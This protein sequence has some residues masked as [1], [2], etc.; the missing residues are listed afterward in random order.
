MAVYN[1]EKYLP[2]SIKNILEQTFSDFEL[3][4]VDDNSK[5]RTLEILKNYKKKDERIRVINNYKNLGAFGALNEGLRIANGSYIAIHDHDDISDINRLST[6]LDVFKKNNN[7]GLLGSSYYIIDPSGNILEK[8]DVLCDEDQIRTQIIKSNPFCHGSIMFKREVIE[9]V[10]FYRSKFKYSGDF[11]FL[12][13]ISEKFKVKNIDKPLYYLRRGI[14][15]ISS[16]NTEEQTNEHLLILD[17]AT[18]RK[19][20]GKDSFADCPD[21][22][23]EEI[24]IN[25]FK[26]NKKEL[27]KIKGEAVLDFYKISL[28]TNNH[29]KAFQYWFQSFRLWPQPWKVKLLLKNLLYKRTH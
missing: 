5:D 16:K 20:K 2:C 19:E 11:D 4:I 1:G 29:L 13:R 21:L 14:E 22:S 3:I 17:L 15:S 27:N 23:I 10:G 24:L 7:L 18:E 6:L 12:L 26:H 25:K 28:R 8:K 9:N